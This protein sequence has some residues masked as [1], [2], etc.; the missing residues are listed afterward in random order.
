MY[1]VA[2]G[3]SILGNVSKTWVQSV[4]VAGLLVGGVFAQQGNPKTT[5]P[6]APQPGQRAAR[7]LVQPPAAAAAKTPAHPQRAVAGEVLFANGR[8]VT[9]A[10]I[11]VRGA[12][13]R[14]VVHGGKPGQVLELLGDRIEAVKKSPLVHG[15]YEQALDAL[16]DARGVLR[17]TADAGTAMRAV[18]K[19]MKALMKA[20]A[21]LWKQRDTDAA[22]AA[23]RDAATAAAVEVK[24]P[25]PRPGKRQPK[26]DG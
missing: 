24:A 1:G 20:R 18:D 10:R 7:V 4:V 25:Q 15:G 26:K 9:T 3:S 5:K 13:M 14:F 23:A 22:T 16:D 12:D 17:T 6:P 2:R 11:A 19:A 8:A 21:A